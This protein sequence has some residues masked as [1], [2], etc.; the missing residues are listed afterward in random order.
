MEN[1]ETILN[2]SE[3]SLSN[4]RGIFDKENIEDK[5]RELEKTTLK[6]NFWKDK[7]LVKKQSNKKKFEDILNSYKKTLKELN[8]LKDLYSLASQEKDR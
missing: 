2:Y 7:D 6:E 3:K 4:I 5:I 1:F 8:N